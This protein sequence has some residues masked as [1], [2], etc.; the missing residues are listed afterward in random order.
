MLFRRCHLHLIATTML[1]RIQRL[2]GALAQLLGFTVHIGAGDTGTQGAGEF[3]AIGDEAQLGEA[4]A[5]LV[6]DLLGLLRGAVRQYREKLLAAIAPQTVDPTQA[7]AQQVGQGA[8]DVVA[9][10]VTMFVVDPFEVID[11]QH[12]HT[13]AVA[14]A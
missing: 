5:N 12:H 11:I 9:G 14:A 4:F 1:G 3:A 8:D 13:G 7:L 10:G 2:V 6:D